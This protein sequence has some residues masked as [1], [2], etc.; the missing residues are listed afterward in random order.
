MKIIQF[1]QQTV[2]P[3]MERVKTSS[4]NLHTR[5][6]AWVPVLPPGRCETQSDAWRTYDA[7]TGPEA[8]MN[9]HKFLEEK[10]S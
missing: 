5:I 6:W 8:G 10:T 4:R 2:L 9:M 7:P 1:I 3:R